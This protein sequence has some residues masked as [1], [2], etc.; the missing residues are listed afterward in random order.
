MKKIIITIGITILLIAGLLFINSN[1]TEAP[2]VLPVESESQDNLVTEVNNGTYF[3][4]TERSSISWTG[5]MVGG[6]THTGKAPIQEGSITVQDDSIQDNSLIINLN[7]I[8]SDEGLDD[9]VTHLKSPDFFNTA[10]FPNATFVAKGVT[11]SSPGAFNIT[12]DLTIKG[13][14]NEII[15]SSIVTESENRYHLSGSTEIDRTLW[16]VR[17]GS[18][19]FFADLG[20]KAIKDMLEIEFDIWTNEIN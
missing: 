19:K 5:N 6:K 18:G 12:G 11:V 17:F 4:D 20:D 10:E 7:N 8:S 15:V 13:I 16:D 3:V 2:T 1:K 9:L 14:T